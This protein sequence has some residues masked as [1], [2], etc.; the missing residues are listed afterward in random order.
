MSYDFTT[1][2]SDPSP[3]HGDNHG[4]ECAGVIA[5]TKNDLCG[6]GVAFDCKI[7]GKQVNLCLVKPLMK[8]KFKEYFK[9]FHGCLP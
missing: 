9:F 6:V 3:F 7:G 5:M 2:T 1:N 8:H 4:T